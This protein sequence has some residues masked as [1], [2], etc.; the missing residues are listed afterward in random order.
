VL[1]SPRTDSDA[2]WIWWTEFALG[3]EEMVSDTVDV[4]S[5]TGY[6]EVIDNK[7]MW[8]IRNQE[9]QIVWENSSILTAADFNGYMAGRILSGT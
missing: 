4:P 9:V 8:I 5:M 3:Y 6:R 7:A 2:P 1:W